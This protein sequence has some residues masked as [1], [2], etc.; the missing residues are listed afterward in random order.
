MRRTV[1]LA[2]LTL[3]AATSALH[4]QSSTE[5]KTFPAPQASEPAPRQTC[6]FAHNNVCGVPTADQL[7]STQLQVI[8][9]NTASACPVGLYAGHSDSL[10]QLRA[11]DVR[12]GV[13][14]QSLNLRMSNSTPHDIVSAQIAVHG[15]SPRSRITPASMG[16][17]GDLTKHMQV[18]LS[19]DA[20]RQAARDV[21][22]YGFT[23][24]QRIDLDSL[25]YADGTTWT[26][27]DGHHCS[28]G[29]SGLMLVAA[30]Q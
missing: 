21:R 10:T 2:A 6:G 16:A 1:L 5:P 9:R 23:S 20:G 3:F 15:L 28:V 19:V 27:S 29:P 22:V 8:T 11:E 25:T 30:S 4:A 13:I 12:P 7:Q 24:V 26:A 18:D 17:G 14:S